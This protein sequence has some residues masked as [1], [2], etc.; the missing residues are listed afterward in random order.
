MRVFARR[1]RGAG[2]GRAAP[3]L[4]RGRS[5]AGWIAAAAV[6]CALAASVRVL[7]A[8]GAAGRGGA[9]E[10]PSRSSGTAA[11]AAAP[12]RVVSINLCTDQLAMLLAAPGQLVSVSFL[13]ADPMTSSMAEMAAGL[14]AN[15]GRA[16]DVFLL[17]PDLVLAGDWTTPATVAMLDRLGVPVVRFPVVTDFDGVR[18]ALRRMGAALGREAAAAEA[19][20]AFDAGLAE[21]RAAPRGQSAILYQPDG[22]TGGAGSLSA[23]ILAAAGYA[24]GGDGGRMSLEELILA[25]PDLLVLAARYPG[26]SRAEAILDHPAVRHLAEWRRSG[27]DWVC[28]T[29]HLLRAVRALAG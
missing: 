25:Q 16:E 27:P 20:A 24:T 21:V 2:A 15:R 10:G 6:L 1:S 8:Q 9:A 29:P 12:R 17:R 18:D 3:A 23:A 28:G 5:V 19:I 22:W 13:A 14:P 4:P 7:E 11:A 26:Q